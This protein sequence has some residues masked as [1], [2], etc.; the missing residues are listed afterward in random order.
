MYGTVARFR[1]KPGMED[2]L[3]EQMEVFEEAHV[4]GAVMTTI[5]RL[6]KD[7]NDYYMAVVFDSKES[8]LANANS[9]E[10]DARYRA[11]MELMA[12]E[13]KWHDGEVVAYDVFK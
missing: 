2:K 4:P 13:P 12:A 10:Q 11:L 3:A 9:P 5:Y 7:P 6:D 1:A 8:Y